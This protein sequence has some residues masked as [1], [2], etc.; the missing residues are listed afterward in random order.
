[1]LL[2][3]P[4]ITPYDTSRDRKAADLHNLLLH[5]K[6]RLASCSLETVEQTI[7]TALDAVL[8]IELAE[9]A[10]FFALSQ[11][12]QLGGFRSPSIHS[13]FEII[14]RRLLKQSPQH[15]SQLLFGRPVVLGSIH[16]LKSCST[17]SR[18]SR[19]N[20]D[21]RS[22]A[23]FPSRVSRGA[24]GLFAMISM[25]DQSG[26]SS[27]I[28][29]ECLMLANALWLGYRQ[30]GIR[31]SGER[32]EELRR[33]RPS[34]ISSVGMAVLDGDG[35]FRAANKAFF[36]ATGYAAD[37]LLTKSFETVFGHVNE[38]C[39]RRFWQRLRRME[40][41]DC[42]IESRMSRKDGSSASMI[43]SLTSLSSS[44]EQ[45]TRFLASI[46]R[47]PEI[48]SPTTRSGSDSHGTR[49]VAS[50]LIQYQESERKRLSRELHD[51]IGQSMSLVTSEIALLTSKYARTS[52]ALGGQLGILRDKLDQVC[53]DLH[54]MSHN[55]HSYKLE[56]LGLK[57][58]VK[59]LC[60]QISGP[61]FLATC[62]VNH[63][64]D[65]RSK[66]AALCLYRI[67]QEA[68]SNCVKHAEARMVAITL[69]SLQS[70]F[71]MTV[72]DSGIG[73]N[74]RAQSS[75]LGLVSMKERLALV[76]GLIKVR[77][78]IGVGT[79]IWVMVP[80]EPDWSEI[81]GREANRFDAYG[82]IDGH[83]A[84]PASLT[85]GLGYASARSPARLH[86][87]K[88]S[89]KLPQVGQRKLA[90]RRIG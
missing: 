43:V 38:R 73:F 41:M 49:S 3:K 69:T 65:P 74:P 13:D 6:K 85:C 36:R 82:T 2:P 21:I 80:D 26:W 53:S 60:R 34:R 55:L 24:R 37:Q 27:Q 83:R 68:L 61:E 35:I 54:N 64:S 19:K 23:L 1:M 10:E 84:S 90:K 76:H 18:F 59:D 66:A 15:R 56:H 75:G 78:K 40:S 72:K 20:M 47:L 7:M 17:T 9:R 58:A 28:M 44:P 39:A 14:L 81:D 63:C 29:D 8:G 45:P 50:Q 67:A 88:L 4:G 42:Q 12:G 71:Y 46:E 62:D 51:G 86:P 33:M 87:A 30:R 57:F 31:Q 77:S 16:D 25:E 5:I 11:S 22:M 48:D 89:S 52:P 70:T 32:A 79:T